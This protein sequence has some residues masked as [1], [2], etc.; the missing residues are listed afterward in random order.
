PLWLIIN[1]GGAVS[2]SM[3]RQESGLVDVDGDRCPDYVTSSQDDEFVVARNGTGRSNLLRRVDR[4]LRGSITLDYERVGNT[5]ELPQSAWALARVD[6]S[7]GV[8][9]DDPGPLVTTL[10]YAAPHFD[11]GE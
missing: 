5:A 3:T 9:D 1:P 2:S 6:L 11:R 4:P 8:A 7:D 10:L